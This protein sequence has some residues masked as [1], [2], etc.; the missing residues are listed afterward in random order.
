MGRLRAI[1]VMPMGYGKTQLAAKYRGCGVVVSDIDDLIPPRSWH[2][3]A[4][5]S[6]AASNDFSS[7][8]KR[9]YGK[10]E[11]AIMRAGTEILLLHADP[12][13]IGLLQLSVPEVC[14]Y[15]ALVCDRVLF[16]RLSATGR[17]LSSVKRGNDVHAC[18]LR[19][20]AD[21]HCVAD[22]GS[23]V[24]RLVQE[25]L[26]LE[27]VDGF[28]SMP[29]D[30]KIVRIDYRGRVECE[31]PGLL[32]LANNG[33]KALTR[34][35]AAGWGLGW[36]FSP[37]AGMTLT[38]RSTV[39]L[40]QCGQRGQLP[41][42]VVRNVYERCFHGRV[43]GWVWRAGVDAKERWVW[44]DMRVA[45][46][47]FQAKRKV[48]VAPGWMQYDSD[49]KKRGPAP[50]PDLSRQFLSSEECSWISQPLCAN[51]STALVTKVVRAGMHPYGVNVKVLK[52]AFPC[53]SIEL[54][55]R[56]TYDVVLVC[57]ILRKLKAKILPKLLRAC[58]G[59]GSQMFSRLGMAY[60][61]CEEGRRMVTSALCLG[62]CSRGISGW[63]TV[64]KPAHAIWRTSGRSWSPVLCIPDGLRA[65]R[66]MYANLLTGR[67]D[68]KELD[69]FSEIESRKE[70]NPPKIV[71]TSSG[72]DPNMFLSVLR[73]ALNEDLELAG[74][75]IAKR[76]RST[77]HDVLAR[78]GQYAAGG[79]CKRLRGALRVEWR[80]TEHEVDNPNKLAW[81]ASLS[82]DEVVQVFMEIAE[83]DVK[84]TGVRK[85]ESGKLRML[86]PGPEAH[87]L[88][89]TLA[90]LDAESQVFRQRDEIELENTRGTDLVHL[91]DRL[92]WVGKRMNV[93]AEDF[94]DFNILQDLSSMADDYRGLAEQIMRCSGYEGE[95]PKYIAADMPLPL[96]SAICA[97][98]AADAMGR[99]HARD[100]ASGGEWHHLARGLW[101][102]WRSTQW[103]NTRFNRGYTKAVQSGV[104]AEYGFDVL[105]HRYLIGDD[106]LLA[107]WGEYEAL[108]RLE[109]YDLDNLQSQASKQMVDDEQAELTRIMHRA[110][111]TVSG[112][113]LRGIANGLSGDLQTGG[114]RPGAEMCRALS[115]QSHMWIRRGM[116]L[117]V[118]RV[119]L[120]EAIKYWGH[121]RVRDDAGKV[122]SVPIP[123]LIIF[124]SA[125]D[126]GLG[127]S[128]FG[129]VAPRL[130]K[131]VP[132]PRTDFKAAVEKHAR[133]QWNIRNAGVAAGEAAYRFDQRGL[134]FPAARAESEM[135]GSVYQSNRPH[136]LRL[137]QE[138]A[139]GGEASEQYRKWIESGGAR[140][141]REVPVSSAEVRAH[142]A[143]LSAI[144]EVQRSGLKQRSH[145]VRRW[146]SPWT[147]ANVAES[148]ALGSAAAA[149]GAL[150]DVRD[151][152]VRVPRAMAI[153]RMVKPKQGLAALVTE[154]GR[155]THGFLNGNIKKP[156][157]VGLIAPKHSVLVDL[158][159]TAALRIYD[160]NTQDD[161]SYSDYNTGLGATVLQ[162]LAFGFEV[163]IAKDPYWGPQQGY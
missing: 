8:N 131:P 117:R 151:G 92:S 19:E 160:M 16:A 142:H 6:A 49:V 37:P 91:M 60:V 75:A 147:L 82:P 65:D 69:V 32:G 155:L 99:L 109:A 103:F 34:P 141:T 22:P 61:S 156:A 119:V 73:T 27:K 132:K 57:R 13:D 3:R 146:E 67:Y 77:L 97:V 51:A 28:L 53:S 149:P 113:L 89:E 9:V 154:A 100:M 76:G 150:D 70:L 134:H 64:M 162:R 107:A 35:A 50:H 45:L 12:Q 159:L 85:T 14:T 68:F 74:S 55:K 84:T 158:A 52:W 23:A 114:V 42:I 58:M 96:V 24:E 83:G 41:N 144:R 17:S 33:G 112:S 1:V 56:E 18:R 71:A 118:G 78:Y 125:L 93:A 101:S 7:Y 20:R 120:E 145:P 29:G 95:L 66:L 98:T 152:G 30:L 46:R 115:D 104:E 136:G 153:R 161:S 4:Y 133:A 31:S 105:K 157:G 143:G 108:R 94:D 128:H 148:A 43:P 126:G 106:S 138:N 5:D 54:A 47:E 111:G 110:D 86:L 135:A 72:D 127:V 124:G 102:G 15:A 26:A 36:A 87:W 81:L 25:R 79:S 88:V 80:G 121:L 2:S 139:D 129:E 21:R 44:E 122:S 48:F 130:N 163:A 90:L 140:S 123:R 59:L 38:E 11:S 39:A 62:L 116:N 63:Q 40:R 137:L 10:L